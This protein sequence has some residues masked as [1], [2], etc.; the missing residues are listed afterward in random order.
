MSLPNG[1]VV[2]GSSSN[3]VEIWDIQQGVIKRNLSNGYSKPWVF[4]LLS[5]GDLIAGFRNNK[6]LLTWDLKIENGEP[7][8]NIIHTNQS[9]YCL[10]VLKNDYLAIGQSTNNFD[11]V[12]IN[13]QNGSIK[14]KFVGH[15]NY[16]YQIIELENGNLV[17]CSSD[18]TVKIWDIK[19]G[20]V[21]KSISHSQPV[22]S[23]AFL[24]NGY[25]ASGLSDGT[26]KIW[27]LET[28]Q[29]VKNLY[30]HSSAICSNN[31]LHV[32]DNGDLLSGSYDKS[33]KVWNPDDGTVILTSKLH[34]SNVYQIS[35]LPSGNILT[36]SFHELTIWN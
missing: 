1:D 19:N 18:L 35:V 25:L 26:I 33:L 2:R 10:T 15:K 36:S 24:K 21:L 9:F 32:L 5:N 7:L 6:T 20:H 8:K 4:G 17:S 11:I 13:S 28:N 29:L 34:K 14:N 27:N 30:G 12:I 23:I 3:L 22:W 16:V 31:C